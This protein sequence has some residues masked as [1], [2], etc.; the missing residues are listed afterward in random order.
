MNDK[1]C[2]VTGANSGIGKYA[3]LGLARAGATVVMVCRNRERGERA[4][5]EIRATAGNDKV[6]LLLADLSSQA[7]IREAAANFTAQYDRLDVL[8][9]NAGAHFSRRYESVD[10]LELTFA[11]NHLGYFLLTNLLLPTIKRSD[12]ARIVNVSSNA[13]RIARLNFDDLQNE[14]SYRDFTVY[15]QSKLANILFTYELARRLQGSQIA[16][17]ATHPGMVNSNFGS[18]NPGLSGFLYGKLFALLGVSS[19]KGAETPLYVAMSP[20]VEGITGGYFANKKQ[21]KSSPASYDE[22]AARRLWAISEDLVTASA[23]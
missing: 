13:H 17:N 2:M 3:A 8:V 7:S 20:T 21:V 1:I 18:S 14:K 10:G 4:Q 5:T 19:E 15:A 11:L 6:D 16:V 12:A 22:E 23:G 9:N